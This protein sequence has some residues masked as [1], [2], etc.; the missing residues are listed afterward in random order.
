MSELFY[1]PPLDRFNGDISKW[2]TSNVENM[3]S[4]FYKSSFNGDISKWDVS[5][6]EDINSIFKKSLLEN[7]PPKWKK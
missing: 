3:D 1:Y 2:N 4:M 5:N 6:V 7:N